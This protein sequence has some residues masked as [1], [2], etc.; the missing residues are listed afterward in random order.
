MSKNQ[1]ELVDDVYNNAL[2]GKGCEINR[3]LADIPHNEREE[4]LKQVALKSQADPSAQTHIPQLTVF[5]FN[6]NANKMRAGINVETPYKVP[7]LPGVDIA[8]TMQTNIYMTSRWFGKES[9]S[10]QDVQPAKKQ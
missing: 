6:S 8:G 2:A 5:D 10:C 1:V 7:V 9:A 3:L 4:I